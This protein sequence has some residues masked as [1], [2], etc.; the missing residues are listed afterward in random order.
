MAILARIRIAFR[1]LR[2]DLA[3][4][5]IGWAALVGMARPEVIA[6]WVD[7]RHLSRMAAFELSIV[8]AFG[9]FLWL[10]WRFARRFVA[11]S[12][13]VS[14]DPA[15]RGEQGTV[16]AEFVF[17]LPILLTLIGTVCEIALIANAALV[18]RH[19]A[20]TAARSAIVS[21]ESDMGPTPIS[22]S[23]ASIA[24]LFQVPPFPEWVDDSRPTEAAAMVMASVSPPL[25][26][27]LK[28]PSSNPESYDA[29]SAFAKVVRAQTDA[30]DGSTIHS[31]Y[32]Y[33]Q[34]FLEVDTIK[35]RFDNE[36]LTIGPFSGWMGAY[37]A[38]LP[39]LI[40]TPK[41]ALQPARQYPT[42]DVTNAYMLPS[43]PSMSD[44]IPDE[45]PITIDVPIPGNA[46]IVASLVGIQP[47]VTVTVPLTAAKAAVQPVTNKMDEAIEILRSG[48]S[49]LVQWAALQWWNVDMFSPKEVELRLKYKFKLNLPSLLLLAPGVAV[50]LEH[51]VTKQ[52]MG[53]AF[54]LRHPT[55]FTARM[56]STGGRRT[57]MG[58]VPEVLDIKGTLG[59][60]WD[61][62]DL[63]KGWQGEWKT[64]NNTPLY[65]R[66]RDKPKAK[67]KNIP[68]SKKGKPPVISGPL[69]LQNNRRT[70]N[71]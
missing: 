26:T 32:E 27:A 13:R 29:N 16:A 11:A 20:F 7:S 22:F 68:G 28:K 12:K 41:H 46:G 47:T 45:V 18:L 57:L 70:N 39:P 59:T 4:L 2:T 23:G 51:P 44:L 63:G 24:A 53:K 52:S 9:V 49:E 5:L 35:E 56:Q 40:P 10:A 1:S 69:H 48:S 8:V 34:A 42:G 65:F 67:K 17:V 58:M 30:W 55:Y 71:P 43:P 25:N 21:F 54:E 19:A 3:L 62:G 31:R 33:A 60:M 37:V 50:P 36:N 15:L 64:V 66:M 61:A 38:S 6:E 14:L